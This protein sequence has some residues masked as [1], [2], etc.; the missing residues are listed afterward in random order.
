MLNDEFC[1]LED[2]RHPV[3]LVKDNGERVDIRNIVIALKND[4]RKFD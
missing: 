1:P 2:R 4:L 3:E